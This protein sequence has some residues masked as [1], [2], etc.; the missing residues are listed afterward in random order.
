MNIE[1]I[2]RSKV[3]IV[4]VEGEL[5]G[6]LGY[7][8]FTS[9]VFKVSIL[10]KYITYYCANLEDNNPTKIAHNKLIEFLE[11]LP[12]THVILVEKRNIK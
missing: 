1:S 5:D 4:E 12:E 7:A 10:K 6:L 11:T 8:Y 3:A 9:E 2:S